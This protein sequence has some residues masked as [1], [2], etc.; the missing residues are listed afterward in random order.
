MIGLLGIHCVWID[1]DHHPTSPES[2]GQ[3]MRGAR[4]G[5]TD[6]LV[7][8]AKD[9]FMRMGRILEAGAQGI[10]YPR[11]D[12]AAEAREVVRWVMS[13][14][15]GERGCDGANAYN[16]HCMLDTAEYVRQANEQTFLAI[17]VESP[18]AVEQARAIAEVDGVD[19]VFFGPG[20]YSVLRGVPGQLAHDSVTRSAET[21]CK[22]TLAAGKRFGTPC[23]DTEHAKRLLDMGATFLT[24]GS[25]IMMIKRSLQNRR[26]E[27]EGS[28]FHFGGP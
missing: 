26:C 15:E 7:R 6:V 1:L 11:C 5:G 19:V 27:F 14:S 21:V 23:G 3:M 25:D 22:A 8:P 20:D 4:A 10:M 16:S 24:H 9:E 28:G 2:A 13:A 18:G 17:Q 12:D